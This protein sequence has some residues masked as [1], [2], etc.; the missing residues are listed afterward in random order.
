MAL[1]RPAGAMA[2][3]LLALAACAG[4]GLEARGGRPDDP[5]P[6]VA[7]RAAALVGEGRRPFEA[8]GERFNPDC[9]GYVEA[10]FAAE[11]IPL[12]ALMQRVAPRARS[13]VAAAFEAVRAYGEA[14][15]AEARPH[16]GDLVF[17]HATWDR[18]GDGKLDDPFTHM[19]IVE[20][21][22]GDTVVFLHRGG[23]R[24]VRAVMTPGRPGIAR[25]ADGREL[26]SPLRVRKGIRGPDLA[27]E[28]FAAYGRI[29]LDR[30]APGAPGR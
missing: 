2:A 7:A 16:P 1:L 12:R 26:N 19:G 20:R 21:M 25:G 6:R 13:G 27:G 11:G 14:F 15:G 5:G 30:I 10:V 22:D 18:D 28:L 4:P 29:E 3:P 24:V 8:A 17:F 9:S 23:D